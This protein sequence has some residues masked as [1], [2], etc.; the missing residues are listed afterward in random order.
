M[1]PEARARAVRA[2]AFALALVPAFAF[3]SEARAVTCR[4]DRFEGS[5]MTLCEVGQDEDLRLFL[6]GPQGPWGG[7]GPLNRALADTGETLSFA[8]NAGMY[9]RDLSPVGLFIEKGI[10]RAPLVTRAGPGNFGMLPNGVFCWGDSGF[11]I[12]ESRSFAQDPPACTY[13]TQSGPL[14]VIG[15]TLHPRF[16]PDSDSALI[17]NGVGVSSDG[18]R[19]VFVISDGPV[20]FHR[21]ARYFRDRLGLDNALYLDGNISRLFAPSL[22]RDDLGR[23][24]GPIV[25][26]VVPAG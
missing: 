26:V 11:R 8:M 18:S 6:A 13:A 5:P 12:V 19:A 2:A 25:G 3:A 24:M 14:L 17:R 22:G 9:H 21:F 10:E 1:R 4:S 15:G 16:L 20:N 7:F 23:N